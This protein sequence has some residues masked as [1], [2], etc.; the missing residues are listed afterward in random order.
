MS[1]LA[2][3][4]PLPPLSTLF[5]PGIPSGAGWLQRI[6]RIHRMKV[7]TLQ[8]AGAVPRSSAG[9]YLPCGCSAMP[10]LWCGEAGALEARAGALE[11][12]AAILEA[13]A[14]APD[15]THTTDVT[16]EVSIFTRSPLLLRELDLLIELDQC[17][18][19]TVTVLIPAADPD[20]VR[21]LE[22]RPSLQFSPSCAADPGARLDLVRTLAA[23]GIAVRVLCTP[24]VAGVNNGTAVLSRLFALARQAGASDVLAAPRH[25]AVPPTAAEAGNL[26][27]LFYRLRLQHG[28]P[29]T[30]PGRG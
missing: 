30:L 17:R 10:E 27:A 28:F 3:H 16:A 24:L 21:R 12:R 6:R 26:A 1:H 18:A 4:L 13:R 5:L 2:T 15:I 20:L 29:R 23:H 7:A 14:A 11:A 9:S 22:P 19:V 25:P 8:A